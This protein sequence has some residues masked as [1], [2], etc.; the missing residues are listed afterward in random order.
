MHL[1]LDALD[2]QMEFQ[3]VFCV[4]RNATNNDDVKSRVTE[5]LEMLM[6]KN[7]KEFEGRNDAPP[8]LLHPHL[9]P[10]LPA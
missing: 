5:V 1:S 2:A 7:F 4:T 10:V 6:P 9:K 3:S 8:S